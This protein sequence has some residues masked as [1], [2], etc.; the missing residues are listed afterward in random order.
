MSRNFHALLALFFGDESQVTKAVSAWIGHMLKWEAVYETQQSD[1]PTFMTQ[2]L[3]AIDSMVKLHLDSCQHA[4]CMEDVNDEILYSS[5]AQQKVIT[6]E[7]T[8]KIP[9]CLCLKPESWETKNLN[10]SGERGGAAGKHQEQDKDQSKTFSMNP[11]F[12]KWLIQDGESYSD[13]FHSRADKFP[14]DNQRIICMKFFLLGKCITKCP[15]LHQLSD[16]AVIAVDKFV[17]DC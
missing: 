12:R 4:K 11:K 5:R 2:V 7:F 16:K 17:R 14:K 9:E 1:D 15:R 8:Q 13:V 3:F 6:L 10:I